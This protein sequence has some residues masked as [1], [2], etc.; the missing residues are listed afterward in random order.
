[1]TS[2]ASLLTSQSA[3]SNQV[4]HLKDE[5]G[6]EEKSYHGCRCAGI[7]TTRVLPAQ[8]FESEKTIPKSRK[9]HASFGCGHQRC[10][11]SLYLFNVPGFETQFVL[12]HHWPLC[13]QATVP[14]PAACWRRW[15]WP[16]PEL[17]GNSEIHHSSPVHLKETIGN[18]LWLGSPP[19]PY[20]ISIVSKRHLPGLL[21]VR[22]CES[23]IPLLVP[24]QFSSFPEAV[25]FQPNEEGACWRWCHQLDWTDRQN[26]FW[27]TWHCKNLRR[28]SCCQFWPMC[29]AWNCTWVALRCAP[30]NSSQLTAVM[31]LCRGA[32]DSVT[33]ANGSV[34]QG[35]KSQLHW[36]IWASFHVLKVGGILPDVFYRAYW[37]RKGGKGEQIF[38]HPLQ[39]LTGCEPVETQLTEA[40]MKSYCGAAADYKIF[41]WF[42]QDDLDWWFGHPTQK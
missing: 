41:P 28:F 19:F 26:G 14:S 18:K 40:V 25:C 7:Q 42:F 33:A 38:G 31:W 4:K 17:I 29:R 24:T 13:S 36:F 39:H 8:F 1:M 16:P 37:M 15:L 30:Q 22:L 23:T 32:Q 35:W 11:F 5:L 3:L 34:H 6:W 20:D 2:F 9:S 27:K 10:Q 12:R 21:F